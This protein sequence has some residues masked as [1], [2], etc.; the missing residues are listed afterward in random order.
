MILLRKINFGNTALKIPVREWYNPRS[1]ISIK[2]MKQEEIRF[3]VR[4]WCVVI[5]NILYDSDE[6]QFRFL[7][8]VT[9]ATMKTINMF[10]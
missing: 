5:K 7:D 2:K 3:C 9:E 8:S 1:K 6:W 4:D 10:F